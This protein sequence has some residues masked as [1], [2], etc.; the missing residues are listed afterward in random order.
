MLRRLVLS[1]AMMLVSSQQIASGNSLTYDF[2]GTLN[3]PI[4]G[5]TTFNGS[6]SIN[7]HPLVQ[8][9]ITS[10]TE[11]GNDVSLTMNIGNWNLI[12]VNSPAPDATLSASVVEGSMLRAIRASLW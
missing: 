2:T 10:I 5:T 8:A 12:Y 4:N 3:K 1:A 7:P 9:G 11:G 6:F